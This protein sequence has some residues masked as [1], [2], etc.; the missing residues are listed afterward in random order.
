MHQ[1]AF[2][3]AVASPSGALTSE[4]RP[5]ARKP[6]RWRIGAASDHTGFYTSS[7]RPT[8]TG[9]ASHL[10][11]RLEFLASATCVCLYSSTLE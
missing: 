6:H 2:V 11:R 10:E 8:C 1:R 3:P 9:Q 5:S 4:G 7:T